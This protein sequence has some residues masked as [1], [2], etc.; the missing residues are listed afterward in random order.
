MVL[1]DSIVEGGDADAAGRRVSGEKHNERAQQAA[2]HR[3]ALV[4]RSHV[5]L[6]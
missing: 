4:S 5:G 6:R 1:G 3:I 2:L